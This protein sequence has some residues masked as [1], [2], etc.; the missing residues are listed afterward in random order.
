MDLLLSTNASS[1][2]T[3]PS[4]LEEISLLPDNKGLLA[5]IS[6]RFVAFGGGPVKSHVASRFAAAGVKLLNHYGATEIGPVA[7]IFEPT[8]EYDYHYFRVRK[9]MDLKM[10]PVKSSKNE[11]QYYRLIARPFGWTGSLEVQDRLVENPNNPGTEFCAVG[12]EDD[13]IILG[14]GEKVVP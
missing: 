7:P 3:V 1:L 11:T 4:I 2:M 5:L 9:D 12:R 14:T 6:L 8:P 10:E 13:M